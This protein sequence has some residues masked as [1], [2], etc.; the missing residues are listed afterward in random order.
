[1][2]HPRCKND[3]SQRVGSTQKGEALFRDP[4]RYAPD[5]VLRNFYCTPRAGS[6]LLS[7][8]GGP[9]GFDIQAAL[10]VDF[11]VAEY[12]VDAIFETGCCVGDTTEY[13]AR[14]YGGLPV[15]TCDI[16][17]RFVMF[18]RARMARFTQVKVLSGDSAE[19]LPS[20]LSGAAMPLI[21]LDAHWR[22]EWPLAQELAG[23]KHGIVVVDDFDIGHPRFGFDT[24]GGISCGLDYVA[25]FLPPSV[26][27]VFFNNPHA[28][29]P[30]PCLQTGRRAG[31]CFVP[32]GMD[33]APMSKCQFFREVHVPNLLEED[34]WQ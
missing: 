24:Y 3:S 20:A 4:V 5:E 30:F 11:L 9:F 19:L 17:Q 33:P 27:S 28:E 23:V 14:R 10:Q 13:L 2:S 22:D 7:D 26:K 32:I 34:T 31:R 1:M 25:K 6:D 16:D 18:T 8:G 21:Y 15:W 29:Y 12:G